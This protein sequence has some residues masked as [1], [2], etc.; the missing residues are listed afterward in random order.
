MGWVKVLKS[1]NNIFFGSV[2]MDIIKLSIFEMGIIS[3]DIESQLWVY[4]NIIK[5]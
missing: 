1:F 5:I 2:A 4:G 3:I